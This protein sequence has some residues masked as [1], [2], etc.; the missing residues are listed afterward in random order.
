MEFLTLVEGR[1]ANQG[2]AADLRGTHGQV[3]GS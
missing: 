3:L 2:G 1:R